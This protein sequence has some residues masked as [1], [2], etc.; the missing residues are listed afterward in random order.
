TSFPLG[1]FLNRTSLIVQAK[2]DVHVEPSPNLVVAKLPYQT[3]A[4]CVAR[5]AKPAANIT[6]RTGGLDYNS[7][8]HVIRNVNG[9][10]TTE[11]QLAMISGAGIKDH[12]VTCIISQGL[13][14]SP[15]EK[16]LTIQNVQC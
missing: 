12:S 8:E 14:L 11:S 5:A 7:S 2:P 13:A 6:W 9:T 16:Q 3:V 10:V 1:A 4:V 15:T